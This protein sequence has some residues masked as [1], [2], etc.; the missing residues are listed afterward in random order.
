MPQTSQPQTEQVVPF[1]NKEPQVAPFP[2]VGV[3]ASAGG[4]E[5]FSRLLEAL[6]VDTGMAFVLIQHLDPTH[7]SELAAILS[8]TTSMNTS[9]VTE[10]MLVEPNHVY[11]IPPNTL[12]QFSKRAFHLIPRPLN[13]GP[14]LT[15]DH[16]FRSLAGETVKAVDWRSAFRNGDRRIGGSQSHQECVRHHL[17]ARRTLR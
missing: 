13:V 3:G 16:F 7:K 5:A 6:P 14:H 8:R 17:R 2:I 9:E 15:I 4:L 11:V 10:G 12:L 1:E